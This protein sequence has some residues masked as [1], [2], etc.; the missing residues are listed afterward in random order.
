MRAACPLVLAFALLA[1][2]QSIAQQTGGLNDSNVRVPLPVPKAVRPSTAAEAQSNTSEQSSEESQTEPSPGSAD[3]VRVISPGRR[4]PDD[5]DSTAQDQD[6]TD[7]DTETTSIEQRPVT[8]LRRRV[9][10][11]EDEGTSEAV[12]DEDTAAATERAEEEGE[13]AKEENGRARWQNARARRFKTAPE[14]KGIVSFETPTSIVP[15]EPVST[16]L[17]TGAT[18]RQLDKMTGKIVTFDL[19]AGEDRQIARLRVRLDA[20]RAP[21]DNDL[22]G[23]MAYL[24]VWDLKQQNADTLFSGWMFAESPALSALDHPR[25]DVW[26][27]S[28]TT[29]SAVASGGN[30]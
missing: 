22:H 7:G 17:K 28:C 1:P 25:Y 4:T 11:N 3:R 24:K 20:C 27:I 2:A 9:D 18:L 8:P 15:I 29:D 21:S 14:S 16:E 10:G 13:D 12:E 23:T 30:E 5:Q 19:G 6:T 26:V